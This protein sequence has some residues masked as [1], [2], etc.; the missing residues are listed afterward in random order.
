MSATGF[1]LHPQLA[2]DTH[3]VT[4]L[5]LC[6]VLLMNESRYPWL[7]LVPRRA[8]IREIHE[9]DAADRQQLWEES[10]QVSRALMALF[11]PDKLNLAALGN[12]V[13]Q[14]HLHYV[15]RFRTD[16]AWPAPVWGKFAPALYTPEQ[17]ASRCRELKKKLEG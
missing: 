13:P 7:I 4:D 16:A 6:R 11:Q 17:A 5:P 12:M 2:Q 14:L 1:E 15:A 9:L 10:D 3:F 8:D